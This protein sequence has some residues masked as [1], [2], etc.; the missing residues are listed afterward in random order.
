MKKFILFI[1]IASLFTHCKNEESFDP[2]IESLE[3]A[4]W[5]K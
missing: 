4:Q 1:F 5:Q 3:D 2:I